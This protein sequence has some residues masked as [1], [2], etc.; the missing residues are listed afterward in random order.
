MV[1]VLNSEI[2]I[3]P[4]LLLTG[5]TW[6]GTMLGGIR[7][8]NT[9]LIFQLFLSWWLTCHSKI[10]FSSKRQLK[11]STALPAV[12]ISIR[13]AN[14]PL[15]VSHSNPKRVENITRVVILK[16]RKH[17]TSVWH[18]NWS[19]SPD[20]HSHTT[21]PKQPFYHYSCTCFVLFLGWKTRECIPKLV[22]SYLEGKFNSDLLITHTLPF[23]K[24]NEGFELL[25][26]GKR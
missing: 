18:Q 22:S 26:A 1:G 19:L 2:S 15:P 4:V 13:H 5:R 7:L 6:K 8:K 24:V 9:L 12:N 21:L 17:L 10:E 14:K 20:P 3:D 23:A 11:R 16:S 25:R